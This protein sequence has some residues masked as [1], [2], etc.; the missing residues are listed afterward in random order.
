MSDVIQEASERV[1][2]LHDDDPID[3]E[4]ALEILYTGK[5][6]S[7]VTRNDV[8]AGLRR[9]HGIYRVADKYDMKRVVKGVALELDASNRAI[10][11]SDTRQIASVVKTYYEI[12]EDSG[13]HFVECVMNKVVGSSD[14]PQC[15][16]FYELRQKYTGLSLDLLQSYNIVV[17]DRCNTAILAH[18]SMR[19]DFGLVYCTSC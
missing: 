14:F 3:F 7:Y 9:A 15:A 12:C 16:E 13:H 18:Y 19:R 1:I 4:A 2:E 10:P 5:H 6:D 11:D 17:C 8:V